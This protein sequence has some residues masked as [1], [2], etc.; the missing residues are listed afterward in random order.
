M[1]TPVVLPP[2]AGSQTLNPSVPYTGTESV[3]GNVIV[4]NS[5]YPTNARFGVIDTNPTNR[6]LTGLSPVTMPLTAAG[7]P[8]MTKGWNQAMIG[9]TQHFEPFIQ[10]KVLEN[11]RFWHD[12]IPRG[13]FQM[14]NGAVHETRVFRGGLQIY[15][16]LQTWQTIDPT[17]SATNNPADMPKFSTFNYGVEAL[18]WRGM[19][20]GWGSEPISIDQFKYIDDAATQLKWILEVGVERGISMQEVFNRDFYI[21]N[22]VNMNRS[23]VMTSGSNGADGFGNARYFYN[24]F[25]KLTSDGEPLKSDSSNAN[26]AGSAGYAQTSLVLDPTLKQPRPFIVVDATNEIEPANFDMLDR[27]RESLTI[28]CPECAV[29]RDGSVPMFALMV[30][31]DDIDNVIRGDTASYD[32]WRR[33]DPKTL[34]QHY[35][36]QLKSYRR[37]VIVSDANQLR[38]KIIRYVP[39][40]SWTTAEA[41]K[42]GNVG[43]E[44]ADTGKPVYIAVAVDPLIPS[45][46]RTGINGGPIPVDNPEYVTAELAIAPVFMNRSFTNLYE[47]SVTTLGSGTYFGPAP[48]LN[49]TWGW[50]NI[51]T[52]KNPFGRIGNF[53]GLYAIHPKPDV[54]VFNVISFVYRRCKEAL[55]ARAPLENKW[56]N[57]DYGTATTVSV[58]A[59]V[60]ANSTEAALA[61]I[62]AGTTVD[63]TLAT[64]PRLALAVGAQVALTLK[65]ATTVTCVVLD[66]TAWPVIKVTPLAEVTISSAKGITATHDA[67]KKVDTLAFD[68]VTIVGK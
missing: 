45:P 37:W 7:Y 61:S 46:I 41:L 20:A 51:I 54:N 10:K 6:P 38:F 68:A 62:A 3:F 22:T 43:L 36:M 66:Q 55:R 11:P 30:N 17:P 60:V 59:G 57:P 27:V 4:T 65:D 56:M 19:R 21:Y 44:L 58:Q 16:G 5:S 64:Q 63:L 29:G 50:K 49:G 26:A 14:F 47:P 1:A 23:F 32:E 31:S 34:I 13:A 42:Y 18:A 67:T 24:P 39:A 8:D 25:C 2:A 35:G 33:G 52:E 40:G 15:S 28:R 9:V 12:R 53:Y 48:A